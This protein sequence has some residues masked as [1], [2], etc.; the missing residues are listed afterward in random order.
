MA[1]EQGAQSHPVQRAVGDGGF[2]GAPEY[3]RAA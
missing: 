3:V 1:V 2:Y